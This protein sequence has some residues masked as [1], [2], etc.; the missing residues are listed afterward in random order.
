MMDNDI[1]LEPRSLDILLVSIPRLSVEVPPLS[2]AQLK[3]SLAKAGFKSQCLDLNIELYHEFTFEEW[4]EI[5]NYFQTDLRYTGNDS[6]GIQREINFE[7]M[8][9]NKKQGLQV[10]E[11]YM[12]FLNRWVDIMLAKR[13]TWIG[14]SV[15]S[16][17]SVLPSIDLCSV[18]RKKSP[19][20]KIMLGGMGVSAFG[21][22]TRP[23]FGEYMIS[24]GLADEYISG[25]GENAIVKLLKENRSIQINPQIDD[26]NSLPFPDYGDF[27]FERYP[28]Q[29]NLIYTTGSRGC[30]RACTFCD[31]NNLWKKFRYRSGENIAD[32]MLEAHKKYGTKEFYFTDSLING[33]VK[34]FV[35]LCEMLVR[36]KKEGKLPKETSFG[37]QWIC[38]PINQFGE[39]Y[40]KIASEAGLYNLS[41]GMESASDEVLESMKKGVTKKDYDFQM[42]MMLKYGIRGNFLMIIGYPTETREDFQKTLNM[43]TEYKKYSDAGVIWG[44]NLG[45]TLVVL[46]GAPL[47]ENPDHFGIDFDERGN[48]VNKDTGL[49]YNERVRRRIRAQRHIEDL[50]Y[51][52]K[53][54]VTTINSLFEIVKAGGYDSIE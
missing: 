5:D 35:R 22:A 16:V 28:S 13:P 38:R 14:V 4:L 40:Y 37:G 23:N 21:V 12:D 54:T 43:F 31:I 10:F 34:E 41:I 51:V 33:N 6:S 3:P 25:E 26:L 17:N 2:I 45:K 29:N 24:V 20:T 50:G 39:D 11:K 36:Y 44:V 8:H 15:F 42:E 46:P 9:E 27:D 19:N 30:V 48:W 47:G 52:V 18:I 1:I 32:E 53:S 7:V 49:T